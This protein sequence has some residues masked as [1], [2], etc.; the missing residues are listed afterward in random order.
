[1]PSDQ[2]LL[3]Y[4]ILKLVRISSSDTRLGFI[5]SVPGLCDDVVIS[6]ISERVRQEREQ[7][8]GD[9]ELHSEGGE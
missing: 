5:S 3:A 2:V 4:R 9:R 6:Y 8:R 1:M 7:H